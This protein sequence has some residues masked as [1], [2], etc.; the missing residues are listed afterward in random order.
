MPQPTRL[1]ERIDGLISQLATT[2]ESMVNLI[3]ISE[4]HE[5]VLYGDNVAG[6]LVTRINSNT[7]LLNEH[8]ATLERLEKASQDMLAFMQSQVKVNEAQAAI[9][10]NLNRVILGLSGVTFLILFLIGVADITALKNL[11]TLLHVP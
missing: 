9:N 3:K 2:N 10:R 11:L 4:R 5:R 1:E 7:Q 6:G 8:Q